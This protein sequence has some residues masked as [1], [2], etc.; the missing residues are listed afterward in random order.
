MRDTC[1]KLES[2]IYHV[3][4]FVLSRTENT[5]EN[6]E[7]NRGAVIVKRRSRWKLFAFALHRC[8]SLGWESSDS[9]AKPGRRAM[10]WRWFFRWPKACRSC[11]LARGEV[12]L[13]CCSIAS[14]QTWCIATLQTLRS[15]WSSV[16][17]QSMFLTC[18][19]VRS[20]TVV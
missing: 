10:C 5:A 13:L 15:V 6:R 8:T 18:G 1:M 11:G 20:L 4:F 9:F 7:T 14:P 17:G 2:V 12:T 3:K 16:L 19:S